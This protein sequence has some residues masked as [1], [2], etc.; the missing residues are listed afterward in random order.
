MGSR[1]PLVIQEVHFP[2]WIF[3][4]LSLAL[5][6]LKLTPRHFSF[7][8]EKCVWECPGCSS[9]ALQDGTQTLLISGRGRLCFMLESWDACAKLGHH[10]WMCIMGEGSTTDWGIKALW[11]TPGSLCLFA[12]SSVKKAAQP[13][14]ASKKLH[15]GLQ[16]YSSCSFSYRQINFPLCLATC[17]LV[18]M[19]SHRR[20]TLMRATRDQTTQKIKSWEHSMKRQINNSEWR[21]TEDV[22]K[23]HTPISAVIGLGTRWA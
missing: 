7:I 18:H 6:S 13:F 22:D 8:W 14:L 20:V 2:L 3:T 9:K 12:S 10:G 15:S 17:I 21:R 23:W 4:L 11:S 1:Q 16:I 5:A 19:E